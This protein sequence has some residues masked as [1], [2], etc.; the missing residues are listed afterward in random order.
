V[1]DIEVSVSAEVVSA[2]SV[3]GVGAEHLPND[4]LRRSREDAWGS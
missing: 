1:S 2:M 4:V 3:K